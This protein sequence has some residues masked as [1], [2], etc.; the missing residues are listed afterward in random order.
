MENLKKTVSSN[1]S[2]LRILNKLTQAELAEKLNYS[3]KAVSKWERGESI[4]DAFVLKQMASIFGVTVDYLLDEHAE[5]KVKASKKDYKRRVLITALSFIGVWSFALLL[6]AIL[7]FCGITHLM[8]FAYAIPV[9][10][11]VLLILNS[12]WKMKHINFH[13][14]SAFVWSILLML[15][16]A[17]LQHN[18][19][20]LFLLG[21]PAQIIIL[22][23]FKIKRCK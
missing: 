6:F 23:C 21:I 19:W 9:S 12:I 10:L 5:I 14:I 7:F 2:R 17:F 8:I 22:L 20:L 3:D 11:L 18:L 16:L 13:L 1:I 15:Y 4:P